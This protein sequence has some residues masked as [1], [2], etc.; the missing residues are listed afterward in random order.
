[1]P[2][3]YGWIPPHVGFLPSALSKSLSSWA[4]CRHSGSSGSLTL[5]NWRSMWP[6]TNYLATTHNCHEWGVTLLRPCVYD[7][8]TA[9]AGL[10]LNKNI[11]LWKCG[12]LLVAWA[13]NSCQLTDWSDIQT[14]I[15]SSLTQTNRTL[16]A[17][18]KIAARGLLI[19]D[20]R[21]FY[22]HGN[23]CWLYLP[24]EKPPYQISNCTLYTR[25]QRNSAELILASHS[26]NLHW[27]FTRSGPCSQ[28]SF[29]ALFGSL[30][31]N[32][33]KIRKLKMRLTHLYFRSHFI[34]QLSTQTLI[35]KNSHYAKNNSESKHLFTSA[36]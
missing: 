18:E 30:E 35:F 34:I 20:Y 17:S 15:K 13:C 16:L 4:S 24:D 14:R 32:E 21:R 31:K 27:N 12:F 25:M 33:N 22:L 10:I 28:K 9:K 36:S 7:L 1:L 23:S 8:W 19:L 11:V 26:M 29:E 6:P 2:S 5:R 3:L